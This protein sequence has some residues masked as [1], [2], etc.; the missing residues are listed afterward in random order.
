MGSEMCI[1]DSLYG[2]TDLTAL[3]TD[4]HKFESRYL[5]SLIG[6]YPEEKA[7][8]ES[9]SPSNHADSITAP[10]LFLQGEEDKVVPPSQAEL[11]IDKLKINNTPVAYLLFEGEAHGFRKSETIKQ[12]LAAELGFYGSVFGFEPAGELSLIHI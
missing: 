6:P 1:R 2:V 3:A 5:D 10:V 12:A 9:R 7:L 4:T 11:M 8:Y